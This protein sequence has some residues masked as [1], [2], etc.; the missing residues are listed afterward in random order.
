MISLYTDSLNNKIPQDRILT[1]R[2]RSTFTL[3]LG[4]YEKLVK[5]ILSE[6]QKALPNESKEWNN[7][8]H[9]IMPRSD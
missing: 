9:E 2:E 4:N 8:R 7:R 5:Y 6:N 1:T 3:N